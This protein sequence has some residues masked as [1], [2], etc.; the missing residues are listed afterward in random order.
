MVLGFH[1]TG[2]LIAMETN[3]AECPVCLGQM[4]LGEQAGSLWLIC[5][6]GCPTEFEAPLAKPAGTETEVEQPELRARAAGF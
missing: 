5:P 4:E 1:Q 2:D 3:Q 6:N